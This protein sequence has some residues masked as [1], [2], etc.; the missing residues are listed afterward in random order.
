[1]RLSAVQLCFF[2][3]NGFI[4][5]RFAV[6]ASLSAEFERRESVLQKNFTVHSPVDGGKYF[7][8]SESRVADLKIRPVLDL[9]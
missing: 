4:C 3:K 7:W 5:A 8:I 6:F 9:F 1:M 2:V